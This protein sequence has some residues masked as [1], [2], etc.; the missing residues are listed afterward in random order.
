MVHFPEKFGLHT[1]ALAVLDHKRGI[2]Y[3]DP[4]G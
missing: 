4:E 3:T 1:H 2:D